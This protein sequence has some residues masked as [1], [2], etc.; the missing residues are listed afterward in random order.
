M[1]AVSLIGA[2]LLTAYREPANK[3]ARMNML[4][5]SYEA[6]IAFTNAY[7]GYVHA[8]AHGIG[9]L[10]HVPHGEAN[11]ILLPKVLAAYGSAVYEPLAR[12]ERKMRVSGGKPEREERMSGAESERDVRMSGAGMERKVRIRGGG[13]KQQGDGCRAGGGVYRENP[14]DEPEHGHPGAACHAAQGGRAGTCGARAQRGQSELP[15]SRDLGRGADAVV[16]DGTGTKV[17][18]QWAS[19]ENIAQNSS[20][21]FYNLTVYIMYAKKYMRF[22][23]NSIQI[24]YNV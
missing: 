22:S 16:P 17:T 11:A 1:K 20:R 8:V 12:L 7:V 13:W 19:Q 6:G 5:G 18:V 23:C 2:N 3:A 10:Y 21:I 14:P 9:G 15:C 24:I 4:T